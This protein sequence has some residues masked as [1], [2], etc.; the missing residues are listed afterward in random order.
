MSLKI[1]PTVILWRWPDAKKSTPIAKR[2]Y[3]M[4]TTTP[5]GTKEQWKIWA[6]RTKV[7][8]KFMEKIH[9]TVVQSVM[10]SN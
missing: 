5:A 3:K 9:T 2:K 7:K 6:K 10:R 1:I 4:N 8:L